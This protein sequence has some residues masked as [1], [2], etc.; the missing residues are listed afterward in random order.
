MT[1]M[2]GPDLEVTV[3]RSSGTAVVEVAAELDLASAQTLADVLRALEAPCDRVILD[4]SR[5]TFIDSIRLEARDHRAPAR[6]AGRL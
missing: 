5:L 1:E 6:R 3:R 2:T 4:L